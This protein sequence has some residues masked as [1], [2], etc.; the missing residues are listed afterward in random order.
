MS[1]HKDVESLHGALL[2]WEWLL[3]VERMLSGMS[4]DKAFE[5]ECRSVAGSCFVLPRKR[6]AMK[7]N[8][9]HTAQG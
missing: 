1:D 5:L 9:N 2:T 6:K 4:L 7:R 3:E 8:G